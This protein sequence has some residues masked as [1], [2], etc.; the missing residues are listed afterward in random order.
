MP[1]EMMVKMTLFSCNTLKCLRLW[2]SAVGALEGSDVRKTAVPGTQY[3]GRFLRRPIRLSIGGSS[4]LV[5]A[6]RM[7]TP[8]RQ[9]SITPPRHT[10]TGNGTQTP[11]ATLS[12]LESKKV[13]STKRK[14]AIKASAAAIDQFQ[15]RQTTINANAVVATMVPLTATP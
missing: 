13:V 3:G 5:F 10:P 4:R 14:G 12:R 8:F 2:S 1:S 9:V 11:S 7:G 15:P 6:G